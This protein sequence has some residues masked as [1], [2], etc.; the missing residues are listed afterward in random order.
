[1]ATVHWICGLPGT[2]KTTF[3]RQLSA[4]G[5]AVLLN[6]DGR[7]RARH[8][9]NPSAAIFADAAAR[10][11]EE[12]WAEAA[13]YL[14]GGRDVVLDWGFWTRAERDD[15]RRRIRAIGAGSVLYQCNCPHD[16]ARRRTVERTLCGG[17][18]VLMINAEAWDLFQ[19]RFEPLGSDEVRAG[20]VVVAED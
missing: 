15:A 20:V 6:H 4:G 7:M 3:A 10:V 11:T 2:G 14:A 18:G 1:M 8:G 5:K 17:E 9:A 12:L 16:L 19:A 13:G